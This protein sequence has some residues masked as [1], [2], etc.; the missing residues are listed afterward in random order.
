MTRRTASKGARRRAVRIGITGPIG[1]GKSTVARWLGERP[2]VVVIDADRLARDVLDPGEPALAAVVARFGAGLLRADGDLD[3]RALGRLVFADPAAL[4]DLEA[5]VHPAVRPRILAG[6]AE[7]E[8]DGAMAVVIEAIKLVEG[9][10]AAACDEV[11]LITCDPVA[12]RARIADRGLSN[13]ESAQRIDAQGDLVSRIA[14]HTTRT[15]DTS[16][17]PTD[18]R[19]AVAAALDEAIERYGG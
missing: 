14:A 4:R 10:L 3:R 8:R 1:C 18:T 15:L 2:D 12:Q 17:S 16:G 11:W 19:S 9:G 5:I 7:A 13:A 6:I